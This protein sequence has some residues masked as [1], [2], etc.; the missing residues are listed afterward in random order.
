MPRQVTSLR[1]RSFQDIER[2]QKRK[3]AELQAKVR[4]GGRSALLGDPF[5]E[6]QQAKRDLVNLQARKKRGY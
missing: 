5:R 1:E 3:V 4:E 6:L 2:M